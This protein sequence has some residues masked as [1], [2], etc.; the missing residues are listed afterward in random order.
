MAFL[1]GAATIMVGAVEARAAD[2]LLAEIQ[3]RG[4]IKACMVNYRPWSM[5]N[6]IEQTW[7]GINAD[8]LHQMADPLKLKIEYVDSSWSTMIQNVQTGKCDISAAPIFSDPKRA[9][10]ISFTRPVG[11]DGEALFVP[12]G[13]SIASL[14]EIDQPDKVIAV[15]SG[16]ASE[17]DARELFKKAKVKALVTD[18]L[19]AQ[20]LEV[21]AGRADAAFGGYA[22][23][24]QFLQKNPNI[25]VQVVEGSTVNSRSFRFAVPAK[26]YYFRDYVDIVIE[27]LDISGKLEQIRDHWKAAR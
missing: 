16:D 12:A 11:G 1:I 24:V 9:A 18:K 17:R 13:S 3:E 2:N 5:K 19:A 25:K 6:P 4:V 27:D 26:E 23:N 8:I 21:A 14:E 7:E 15:I 22:G 10:L 20:I